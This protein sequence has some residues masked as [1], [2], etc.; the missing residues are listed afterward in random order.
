MEKILSLIRSV[1]DSRTMYHHF[2]PIWQAD[3]RTLLGFEALARF[4]DVAPDVVFDAAVEAGLGVPLDR[5]SLREALRQ[6]QSLPG[7]LFLNINPNHLGQ[8]EG[9]FGSVG[10]AV[11]TFRN[12]H[13][14]VLE[15]TEQRVSEPSMTEAGILRMRRRGI[16]L[17]LD[18]AGTGQSTPQRLAWIQ[19]R[20]VKIARPVIEAWHSG[21]DEDLRRWIQLAADLK[22][23][24]IAEG[25]EDASLTE[26]LAALGVR[27]FQGYALGRPEEAQH[28]TSALYSRAQSSSM[29][30]ALSIFTPPDWPEAEQSLNPLLSVQEIGDIMYSLWPVPAIIVD[31]DNRIV[32]MNLRAERHFG[33]SLEHVALQAV[34]EMLGLS[35]PEPGLTHASAILPGDLPVGE[36]LEQRVVLHRTDGKD[37]PAQLTMVSIRI[38]NRPG[39]YKLFTFIPEGKDTRLSAYL[40]RDPLS[41]LPT[42]AWWE[43]ELPRFSHTAGAVIF[44]DVDGLKQVNDLFGHGEGD[45]VLT[46]AGR[47]ILHMAEH[48]DAV[49]VRYGGDEFLIVLPHQTAEGAGQLADRLS[50]QF[51]HLEEA[52]SRVPAAFSYGVAAFGPGT[53]SEAIAQADRHLYE[54][55]GLLLTSRAGGR[56]MLT[57]SGRRALWEPIRESE[58]DRLSADRL[59]HSESQVL[60][61]QRLVDFIAP[62][63]GIAIVEVNAGRGQLGFV[64]GLAPRVGDGAQYLAIDHQG[65]YLSLLYRQWQAG[66]SRP[67]VHFLRAASDHLP[68]VSQSADLTALAFALPQARPEATLK[69]MVRIT[70]P[71]GLLAV[72]YVASANLCEAL[73]AVWKPDMR[74]HPTMTADRMT[75]LADDLSLS[76]IRQSEHAD[77]LTFDT[78]SH[79]S[80]WMA[81]LGLESHQ[82]LNLP[83]PRDYARR[84]SYVIRYEAHFWLFR[85]PRF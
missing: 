77:Q 20:Y 13:A 15:V 44:L 71:D 18:D 58:T 5:L 53:L 24:L 7:Y 2:Q 67:G 61:R 4:D 22:A 74:P 57:A 47:L 30:P 51:S 49:A 64:G 10:S 17:A 54:H 8:S 79:L 12:R 39:L 48:H 70:R 25:I 28:W 43:R 41:G 62:D 42:R 32:G 33:T 35:G 37:V 26:P 56:L 55:K 31:R 40:G 81:S 83:T 59:A 76:V 6:G 63:L 23:D 9:P 27:Y 1:L 45:R 68:V 82:L 66:P 69:E 73:S 84:E 36:S 38:G 46:D 34:E 65:S 14:V 16:P 11:A 85:R 52:G 29:S 78:G 60:V 80:V 19:P 72:A 50:Q 21:N 3:G 75:A